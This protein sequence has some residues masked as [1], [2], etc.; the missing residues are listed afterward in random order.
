MKLEPL[1]IPEEQAMMEYRLKKLRLRYHK[2][3]FEL[4]YRQ[5]LQ[6]EGRLK[7]TR[8]RGLF[9]FQSLPGSRKNHTVQ[10]S[11]KIIWRR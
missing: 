1:P 8:R 2:P 9:V 5:W 6:D 3:H 11:K 10:A 4:L 7:R